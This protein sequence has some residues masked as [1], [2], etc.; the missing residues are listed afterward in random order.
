VWTLAERPLEPLYVQEAF[1]TQ[2]K[3]PQP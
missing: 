1:I 3:P 2:P